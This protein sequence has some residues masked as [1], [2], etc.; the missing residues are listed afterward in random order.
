M[1]CGRNDGASEMGISMACAIVVDSK[2]GNTRKLA[3]ALAA[4]L[5]GVV[6][7]VGSPEA[8]AAVDA[9]DT[10]LFGFWC[11]KG[12]CSEESAAALAALE[13]KRVFLFG[14]AGFGGSPEYFDR[15]LGN[16]RKHLPAS[17]QLIGE[18]MCQGRIDPAAR[19]KWEAAAQANPADPRAT[20]MLKTFD[21]AEKH[22]SEQDL[23]RVVTAAKKALAL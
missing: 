20:M 13:G 7:A 3:D 10:V 17:A 18:I 4:E 9:A 15:V 5:G 2:T 1:P 6:C 14:T 12:G 23:T 19:S 8:G 21:A 22:P 11:D 16:V